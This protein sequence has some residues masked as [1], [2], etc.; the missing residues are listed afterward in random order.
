M[1]INVTSDAIKLEKKMSNIVQSQ[2]P[3]ATAAALTKIAQKVMADEKREMRRVFDQPTPYTMRAMAIRPA[4]KDAKIIQSEVFFREFAGKGTPA[5]KYLMPN[6][7]GGM[8]SAK[9]HE[10]ALRAHGILNPPMLTAPARDAPIDGRG[11]MAGGIYQSILSE[12]GAAFYASGNQSMNKTGRRRKKKVRGYYVV[13]KG[14]RAVGIRQRDG[15][16]TKRILNFIKPVAYQPRFDF[17]G[18]AHKRIDLSL[19]STFK[20]WLKRAIRTAR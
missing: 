16:N 10:R 11:N 13:K 3:F 12:V 7:K 15:A 4:S 8:R 2:L 19:E 18:V 14:G 6:I 5:Y 1:N 20:Y 9:R 17:Y